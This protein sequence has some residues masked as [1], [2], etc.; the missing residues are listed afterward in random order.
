MC[1]NEILFVRDF[2]INIPIHDY[3]KIKYMEVFCT[4]SDTLYI[5][6]TRW[7]GSEAEIEYELIFSRMVIK[8]R[9]GDSFEISSRYKCRNR[10][11]HHPADT[12]R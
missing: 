8:M 1:I 11:A 4:G 12:F 6:W 7:E 10:R 9:I 5:Y 3:R 2:N